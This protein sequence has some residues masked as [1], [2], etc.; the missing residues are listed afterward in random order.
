[1]VLFLKVLLAQHDLDK[2]FCGGLGSY[3]LYVLVAYHIQKHLELGGRDRPGEV[4]LSF[5]YRFGCAL[6]S[7]SG[8]KTPPSTHT[9]LSRF[10]PVKCR[11]GT[12][13]DLSNV[14]LLEHCVSLFRGCS[15]RLMQN[16]RGKCHEKKSLFVSIF[17]AHRLE[18][19][20]TRCWQQA[21]AS[22]T[23][24]AGTTKRKAAS[25][26]PAATA[27]PLSKQV[28]ARFEYPREQTAAELVRGYQSPPPPP[29]RPRL[30]AALA[31]RR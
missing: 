1:M 25:S 16:L 6:H 20:R 18:S 21:K 12:V 15:N 26:K 19:E 23:A 3:K 4:L 8:T 22:S 30:D 28:I 9:A 31:A 27:K 2:P 10:V 13:A 24:G 11:D 7:Y 14:F 17:D 29:K 5:L